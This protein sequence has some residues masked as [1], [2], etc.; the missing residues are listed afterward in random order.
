[1]QIVIGDVQSLS[2]F[3]IGNVEVESSADVIFKDVEIDEDLEINVAGNIDQV[4]T[5]A[6]FTVGGTLTF[7]SA[8]DVN[9][10]GDFEVV[11]I[12]GIAGEDA[13]LK[14]NS[15][16]SVFMISSDQ[17]F[18]NLTLVAENDI[19]LHSLSVG[20]DASFT[21]TTG[22]ITCDG[23][24]NFTGDASFDAA[25][26]NVHCVALVSFNVFDG[27]VSVT[28][29]T[30]TI[31]AADTL[32]LGAVD[33][34]NLIVSVEDALN[35]TEAIFVSGLLHITILS[36]QQGKITLDK[37]NVLGTNLTISDNDCQ[38]NITDA[39]I[40]SINTETITVIYDACFTDNILLDIPNP[41]FPPSSNPNQTIKYT[42]NA[43]LTITGDS[44][45]AAYK[46]I[47]LGS[48]T[49]KGSPNAIL[50]FTNPDNELKHF[51][52]DFAL[53]IELVTKGDFQ[54]DVTGKIMGDC[55]VTVN[56]GKFSSGASLKVGLALNM[57]VKG[58]IALGDFDNE[59]G[60][61]EL[62]SS[63]GAVAVRNAA[64]MGLSAPGAAFGTVFT[65]SW[66]YLG[67]AVMLICF[68]SFSL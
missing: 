44:F 26:G 33:V 7:T 15:S 58:D 68:M 66:D 21:S 23:A 9:L 50:R 14:G 27:T 31:R 8:E 32:V 4:D 19:T 52:L 42:G 12:D 63:N 11:Y 54:F 45:V 40:R 30:A 46:L 18:G 29:Q 53:E 10:S 36:S 13:Y 25:Q 6:N 60:H 65:S 37:N 28:A 56:G 49:I 38:A 16:L 51:I 67:S 17:L 24:Q 41:Y 64:D 47:V 2:V 3:T 62:G 55:A 43:T 20:G 34:T 35:S 39:F 1:M 48:L 57:N 5:S 22:S 59:L 61:V